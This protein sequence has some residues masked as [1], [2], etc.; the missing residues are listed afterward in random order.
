MY[1][2]LITVDTMYVPLWNTMKLYFT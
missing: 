2:E 1:V